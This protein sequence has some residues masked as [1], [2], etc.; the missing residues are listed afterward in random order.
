MHLYL[1]SCWY[2]EFVLYCWFRGQKEVQ[3]IKL[4]AQ[5]EERSVNSSSK[6]AVHY[7]RNNNKVQRNKF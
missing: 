3:N 2:Y 1:C 5:T 4:T 6:D 7:N